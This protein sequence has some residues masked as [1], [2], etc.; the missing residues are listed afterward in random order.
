MKIGLQ[1]YIAFQIAIFST[2]AYSAG[3]DFAGNGGGRPENN[4]RYAF[5]NMYKFIED[6]TF[7]CQKT[8][9]QLSTKEFRDLFIIKSK[10]FELSYQPEALIYCYEQSACPVT[11]KTEKHEPHKSMVAKDQKIYVNLSHF[12]DNEKPVSDLTETL[13]LLFHEIGHLANV[14]HSTI[15]SHE[16]LDYLGGK[17]RHYVLKTPFELEFPH[18]AQ[19]ISVYYFEFL[20]SGLHTPDMLLNVG[21]EQVK[22][23]SAITNYVKAYEKDN[24]ATE[25]DRIFI[26]YTLN[27]LHW[28][29]TEEVVSSL[30]NKRSTHISLSGN[31]NVSCNELSPDYMNWQTLYKNRI[32]NFEIKIPVNFHKKSMQT[33][34]EE[35]VVY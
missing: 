6:F 28:K 21:E 4:I 31:I 12:Y 7:H 1:I 25:Q 27:N 34:E 19:D 30:E 10:A 20:E 23:S 16:Y 35:I 29:T 22:L 9:C 32:F 24:C 8:R 14:T 26:N 5:H 13:S 3:A 33:L 18:I 11:F 2:F 17:I 15:S